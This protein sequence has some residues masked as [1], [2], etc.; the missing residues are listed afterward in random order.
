M[1]H[2]LMGGNNVKA[3]VSTALC[4]SVVLAQAIYFS[5]KEDGEDWAKGEWEVEMRSK[6]GEWVYL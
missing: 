3:I 6:K 5:R 2:S 4:P 1:N